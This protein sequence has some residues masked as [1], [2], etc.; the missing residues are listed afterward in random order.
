MSTLSQ[1][2]L[3]AGI[4]RKALEVLRRREDGISSD[5]T[6]EKIVIVETWC[7]QFCLIDFDHFNFAIRDTIHISNR[8]ETVVL[9]L[10]RTELEALV[11]RAQKVLQTQ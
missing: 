3:T 1:R 2:E 8:P 10:N 9:Y 5:A 6:P 7:R 4:S 11:S